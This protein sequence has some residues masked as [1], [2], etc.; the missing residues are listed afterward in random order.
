MKPYTY[1][2]IDLACITIPFLASFYPKHAFYKQWKSFFKANIIVALF[3]LIWDY[4]FTKM[5]VWGFNPDY[6][7]GIYLGN[8]P[9]EEVLFFICI[10]F[11]CV[12]TF[13][14]L[15]YLIKKSYLEK[16]QRYITLLCILTFSLLAL[17]NYNKWYTVTACGFTT[18]YLI[19]LSWKQ[20]DLSFHYLS[21]FLILPFFFL[22]NG[23][24]TGSFLDA[25]I[26]WYNNAENLSIRIFTIPIEDSIYGLLLI[27][28]NI[29]GFQYFQSKVN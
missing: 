4:F 25:A 13:F 6:L 8:L 14:A 26:V 20:I 16:S 21:Y 2:L 17:F 1:L 9:I 5:G 29:E 7:S 18:F 22:S 23:L 15:K 12:F 27:F 19:Y 3:F 11:A 28:L 10:P 24:L